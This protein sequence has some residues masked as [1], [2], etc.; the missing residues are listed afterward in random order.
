MQ[1]N[2][3]SIFREQIKEDMK[4]LQED[5]SWDEKIKDNPAYTFNYWVLINMYHLDQ[6]MCFNHITEYKDK[7]IDCY[8][9]YEENKELYIIQNKYYSETTPLD[10]K[11]ISDFLT[12]PIASLESGNYKNKDLQKAYNTAKLDKD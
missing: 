3:V 8:V 2:K 6:E 12:R 10:N 1:E 11:H 7:G 9:H 4:S 5:L